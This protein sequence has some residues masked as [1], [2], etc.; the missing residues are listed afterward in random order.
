MRREGRL[1]A[2][3]KTYFEEQKGFSGQKENPLH[4][5]LYEV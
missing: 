5:L 2:E 3:V 4:L 1:A